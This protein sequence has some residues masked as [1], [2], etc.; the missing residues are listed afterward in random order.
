MAL[1][2][3]SDVIT[4]PDFAEPVES[5]DLLLVRSTQTIDDGGIAS[6]VEGVFPLGGVVCSTGGDMKRGPDGEMA[7]DSFTL[8]TLT[9]LTPGRTPDTPADIVVWKGNRYT[10]V[11][12]N[13]FSNFGAGFCA[14]DCQLISI[15]GGT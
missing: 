1:L 4:D 11:G 2:D 15:Q 13:N 5:G 10:V 14:A 6:N 9:S 7:A 12:V 8:H 3:M